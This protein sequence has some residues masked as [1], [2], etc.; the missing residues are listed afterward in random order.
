MGLKE[1]KQP[2]VGNSQKPRGNGEKMDFRSNLYGNSTRLF[3]ISSWN[4]PNP[5]MIVL[6]TVPYEQMKVLVFKN[7]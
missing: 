1:V 2:L 6:N 7:M 5:G 3:L 4:W